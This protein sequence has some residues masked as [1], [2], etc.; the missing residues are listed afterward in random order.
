LRSEKKV[1]IAY[2]KLIIGLSCIVPDGIICFFPSY[3]YMEHI[4]KQWY[5][6]GIIDELLKYKYMFIE[7]KD[8]I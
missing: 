7:K 1:A 4:L 2:G 5:D 6:L 8:P 3:M